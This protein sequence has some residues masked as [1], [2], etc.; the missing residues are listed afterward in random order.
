MIVMSRTQIVLAVIYALIL[1]HF[2]YSNFVAR[3]GPSLGKSIVYTGAGIPDPP[4]ASCN[5]SDSCTFSCGLDNIS[6]SKSGMSQEA[7]PYRLIGFP[8]DI[9]KVSSYSYYGP[10]L[11]TV[12]YK[13]NYVGIKAL[14][15][16][17]YFGLMTVLLIWLPARKQKKLASSAANIKVSAK[18]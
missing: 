2:L 14:A 15:N 1:S 7:R 5:D 6:L 13:P 3:I 17:G 18:Q 10:C 9:N 4:F 16:A 12:F 11:D 8:L